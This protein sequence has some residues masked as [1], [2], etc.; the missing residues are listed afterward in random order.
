MAEVMKKAKGSRR[1]M[2][3]ERSLSLFSSSSH[4]ETLPEEK[5]NSK[6][7]TRANIV[8]TISCLSEEEEDN[9]SEC[10][11]NLKAETSSAE[12]KKVHFASVKIYEHP[13]I[14]GDNPGVTDGAPIQIDW[15]SQKETSML[16]DLYESTREKERRK[17]SSELKLPV[18]VRAFMLI[19]A[20]H[21]IGE[22]VE[23]SLEAKETK[24]LRS[25]SAAHKQRWGRFNP[26][27]VFVK[28]PTQQHISTA[29]VA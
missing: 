18:D 7:P 8:N 23:A 10:A 28:K 5:R 17:S 14:L 27:K 24:I 4:K 1:R 9:E 16:V 22:I 15:K 6:E 3:S 19:H 13:I 26:M 25:A 21:T 20:G 11:Y 2:D 29:R 12:M